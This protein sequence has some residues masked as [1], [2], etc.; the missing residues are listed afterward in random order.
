[1]GLGAPLPPEGLCA[2]CRHCRRVPHPRG[3]RGY[4]YCAVSETNPDFPRYP[5]LPV[6]QCTGYEPA[7]P[8]LLD[9]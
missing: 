3:G 8:E 7:K 1:M 4:V 6:F 5:R 9:D 2:T